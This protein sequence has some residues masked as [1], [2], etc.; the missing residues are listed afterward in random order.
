MLLEH[1]DGAVLFVAWTGEWSSDIFAV[2]EAD[3]A[4]FLE[5]DRLEKER[6]FATRK[7]SVEARRQ[8][9]KNR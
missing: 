8:Q 2:T 3:V 4:V 5:Q 1:R 9:A 7:A 6:Q